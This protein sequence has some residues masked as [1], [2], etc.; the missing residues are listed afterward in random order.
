MVRHPAS[1]SRIVV[2][3]ALFLAAVMMV[4]S[5]A[6]AQTST[7]EAATTPTPAGPPTETPT[8][9]VTRTPTLTPTPTATL[10]ELEN[11]LLLADAYLNG[12]EF[13]KAAD[14]YS[15]ILAEERGQPQALAGLNKALADQAAATATASAPRPTAIPPTPEAPAAPTFGST[16]QSTLAEIAGSVLPFLLI[17]LALY[18]LSQALRWLMFAVRELFY[19]NVLPFFQRPARVRP[20]LIGEFVD[21]T[22]QTGRQ[23]ARRVAQ[24]IT[25]RLLVW[26]QLVQAK[27]IPV[28]PAPAL[29]FGGMAWIRVLWAWLIPPSRAYQID[30]VLSGDRPGAYQLAVRRTNLST[31]SVDAGR[32][33]SSPQSDV[34]AAFGEMA[35]AAAIWLTHPRDIEAAAAAVPARPAGPGLES[36]APVPPSPSDIYAEI[37]GLLLPVRQQINVGK[38]DFADA[39]QRLSQAEALLTSLPQGSSLYTDLSEVI[40]DLRRKAPGA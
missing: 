17:V 35:A 16:V 12:G 19:L 25:E 8:P 1:Y 22:G 38:V 4:P 5:I 7:P 29:D 13:A 23:T 6:T 26:N 37:V 39:R 34:D 27:E 3:I 11:R 33:F 20:F 9:T 28:E 30:G 24:T 32:T 31:N 18:V 14:L 15:A 10:T 36:L 21:A 2:A 40:A